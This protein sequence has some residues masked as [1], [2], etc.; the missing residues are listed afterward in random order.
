MDDEIVAGVDGTVGAQTA[1]RWAAREAAARRSPLRLLR[2]YTGGPPEGLTGPLDRAVR[3][4]ADAELL[5]LGVAPGLAVRRTVARGAPE[6]VLL[7]AARDAALVVVGS[8][9]RGG[10]SG[11]LLGSVSHGVAAH[12]AGPVVVVR[13]RGTDGPV[14]V[15]A[16]GSE[17]GDR[18]VAAAFE[19]AAVHGC[20][21]VA[22]RAWVPQAPALDAEGR[23]LQFEPG[24]RAGV[25]RWALGESVGRWREKF[26]QVPVETEVTGRNAADAR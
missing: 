25:E 17:A 14:V 15:G 24:E 19:F 23:P 16:D 26:P 12:A 9:G 13:G 8:R 5:A 21:L 2:A 6:T 22:V 3:S 18:A 4:L 10:V 1:V 7:A 11:A 20:G